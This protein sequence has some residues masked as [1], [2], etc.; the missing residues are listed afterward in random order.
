MDGLELMS[1]DQ[2]H[3]AYWKAVRNRLTRLDE[4]SREFAPR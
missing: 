4:F 3:A 2:A 1:A